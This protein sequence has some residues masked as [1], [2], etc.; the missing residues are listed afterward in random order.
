MRARTPARG[1]TTSASDGSSMSRGGRSVAPSAA[2]SICSR[3]A[4]PAQSA[5]A[6][7]SFASG[8]KSKCT[9]TN[10]R[11]AGGRAPLA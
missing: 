5:C 8:R 11:K 4:P 1:S 3:S 9:S 7:Q 2:G 6:A 10:R